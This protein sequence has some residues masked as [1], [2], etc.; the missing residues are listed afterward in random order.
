M[1]YQNQ[2]QNAKKIMKVFVIFL[3]INIVLICEQIAQRVIFHNKVYTS[4]D[5]STCYTFIFSGNVK[6]LN[7]VHYV[8]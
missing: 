4:G 2:Q 6:T 8:V 5:D 3:G 1:I 7:A